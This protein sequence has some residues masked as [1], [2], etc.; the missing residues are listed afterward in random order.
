LSQTRTLP[1]TIYG[2]AT[3][4]IQPLAPAVLRRRARRGKEDPERIGE[5]LGVASTPRPQGVLVWLHGAS[6][7]ESLSLLPLIEA[8]A[9]ARP[10]VALLVT[11]GTRTSADLLA[12]RLPPGVIHQYAPVDTPSAVRRFLSHWRPDLGLL[13]ESELWPNLLLAAHAQG[14]RIALLSAKLSP[15]SLRG[16]LR[17]PQSAR[18]LLGVFHLILA[19]DQAAAEAFAQLGVTVGGLGDLKFGAERLPVDPAALAAAQAAFGARPVVLAASTHPGEDEIILD[20]YAA[21]RA[22]APDA[23]LVI[24]PRHPERGL[25][26]AALA[27]ARGLSVAVRSLD[28][29]PDEAAVYVADTLGELGLWFR[30]ARLAVMGGSFV[31]GI[32]GHN[33]LEPARLCCPFA[34][35]PQV[36]NW[37]GAYRDLWRVLDD[38]PLTSR[39]ELGRRI[40]RALS[41][42]PEAAGRAAEARA[43]VAARDI[44]ARQVTGQVLALLPQPA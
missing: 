23:L 33:P 36:G 11:S 17:A 37:A 19:K 5:R 29:S 38:G 22:G 40:V 10:D 30:L 31:S 18:A 27:W 7:G 1:L 8:I 14:A 32:G 26:V 34:S 25:G 28:E 12:S 39:V 16:W 20:A 21:A 15:S 42:D 13:V 6:V 9:A 2:A 35:G 24:V 3:A 44:D 43:Y 4:L 41:G